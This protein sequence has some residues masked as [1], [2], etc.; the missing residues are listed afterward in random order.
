MAANK[1]DEEILKKGY[2]AMSDI[3]HAYKMEM[4]AANELEKVQDTIDEL[5]K[6]MSSSVAPNTLY[7]HM[8]KGKIERLRNEN[9]GWLGIQEDY[10]QAIIDDI[11]DIVAMLRM[12]GT[13]KGSELANKY[14]KI[15]QGWI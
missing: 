12:N 8:H 11:D 4:R 1:M 5:Y 15:R 10:R 7:C 9:K 14:I 2:L 3:D 6:K 13:N